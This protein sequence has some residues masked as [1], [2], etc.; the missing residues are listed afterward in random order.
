MAS[1]W[2][3]SEAAWSVSERSS[4]SSAWRFGAV[5]GHRQ[6][7]HQVGGGPGAGGE[8][9]GGV[10]FGLRMA[11]ATRADRSAA[12]R[13]RSTVSAACQAAWRVRAS[14]S[15]RRSA[16]A[17]LSAAARRKRGVPVGEFGG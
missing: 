5:G 9:G 6:G 3:L 12:A 10:A 16:A 17:S 15:S 2:A 1:R 14:T 8:G 11:A 13:W 7:A 4:S